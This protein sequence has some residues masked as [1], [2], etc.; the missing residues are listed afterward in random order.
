MTT[1]S[2]NERTSQILISESPTAECR[3]ETYSQTYEN[4]S[5]P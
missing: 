5:K 4:N 3:T 2:V 1:D